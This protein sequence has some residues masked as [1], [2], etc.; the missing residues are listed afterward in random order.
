MYVHVCMGKQ[1]VCDTC[2]FFHLLVETMNILK[3]QL[4]HFPVTVTVTQEVRS[5][6]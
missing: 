2:A 3:K 4:L 5:T 6:V 1:F